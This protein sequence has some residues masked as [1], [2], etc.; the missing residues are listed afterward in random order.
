[1]EDHGKKIMKKWHKPQ[2]LTMSQNEVD[3][4]VVLSAWRLRFKGGAYLLIS[5]S[6]CLPHAP[7]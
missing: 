2:L 6:V 3:R 5:A 4:A 1:M 7:N